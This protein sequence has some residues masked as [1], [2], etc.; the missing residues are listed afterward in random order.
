MN[1][2]FVCSGNTCRS[3]MAEALFKE[4]VKNKNIE[5]K[6]AGISATNGDPSA[7]HVRSILQAK[8]IDY[9]HLSQRINPELI[10]WADLILTMTKTQKFLLLALFPQMAKYIFTLKEY[11]TET[12]DLDIKDPY[13]SDL[14]AYLQCAEEIEKYLNILLKQ[15]S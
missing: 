9:S 7:I 3:P 11:T 1:I 8:K 14:L 10:L 4:L 12:A 13:G 15:L 2:L 5:V 6:S